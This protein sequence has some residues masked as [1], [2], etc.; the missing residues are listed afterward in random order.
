MTTLATV[1]K[2]LLPS[3]VRLHV[4]KCERTCTKQLGNIRAERLENGSSHQALI[5]IKVESRVVLTWGENRVLIHHTEQLSAESYGL[6]FS[7]QCQLSLPVLLQI[8]DQYQGIYYDHSMGLRFQRLMHW[9]KALVEALTWSEI[10][11]L[12]FNIVSG[13]VSARNSKGVHHISLTST[14]RNNLFHWGPWEGVAHVPHWL[15]HLAVITQNVSG[16]NLMI[17]QLILSK[18]VKHV[19]NLLI[20]ISLSLICCDFTLGYISS[21]PFASTYTVG[22]KTEDL[23]LKSL[24]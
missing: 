13:D 3:W 20:L 10:S 17:I 8:W 2:Q 1:V 6:C 19:P 5:G 24:L 15:F 21:G 4:N 11:S 18:T 14:F 9:G 22:D 7:S 12:G 23:T 16:A